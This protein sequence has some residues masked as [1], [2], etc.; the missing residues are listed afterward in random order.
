MSAIA[1]NSAPAHRS[2]RREESGLQKL[3]K[4]SEVQKAAKYGALAVAAVGAAATL[5]SVAPSGPGPGPGPGPA[6]T[7]VKDFLKNRVSLPELPAPIPGICPIADRHSEWMIMKLLNQRVTQYVTNLTS[8]A[9]ETSYDTYSEPDGKDAFRYGISNGA[10]CSRREWVNTSDSVWHR[11]VE[12]SDHV[13][14]FSRTIDEGSYPRLDLTCTSNN[15]TLTCAGTVVPPI[16]SLHP[17]PLD[18]IFC[19][20]TATETKSGEITETLKAIGGDTVQE[21]NK[22]P[23]LLNQLIHFDQKV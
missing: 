9:K 16:G 20:Y 15:E 8:Q 19:E 4:K 14:Q 13:F 3:A 17:T 10:Q 23:V 7:P 18:N 11:L 1:L 12:Q 21:T 2:Q 6:H 22:A 5:Y